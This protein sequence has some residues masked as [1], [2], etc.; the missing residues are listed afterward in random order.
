MAGEPGGGVL[1]V[2]EL[3]R[4]TRASGGIYDQVGGGFHRYSTD[5]HWLV[6]HFEKMLYDNALLSLAYLHAW[7]LT[8]LERYRRVCEETLDY[9]LR[10]MTDPFGG[11]YSTQ[12]A[13]SEGEEGKFY[14]WTSDEIPAV[15]GADDAGALE[16]LWGISADWN[17]EGRNIPHLARAEK[18]VAAALGM[19]ESTLRS[20]VVSARQ[21]LYDARARRV[22][23]GKDDKVLAA[24]NGLMLRSFAEA[25]RV[26]G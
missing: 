24:W 5:A 14:V 7:Q 16:M 26:F 6:P 22:A 10:E 21:R 3:T 8:G 18:D 20:L 13:D 19:S 4:G 1:A 2:A 23:P 11:F 9:V 17:F 25:A 15:V 12:D